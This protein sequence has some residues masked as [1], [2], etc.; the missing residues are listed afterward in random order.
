MKRFISLLLLISLFYVG[1]AQEIGNTKDQSETVSYKYCLI[2]GTEK[3]FSKKVK[4]EVDFGQEQK[5]FQKAYLRDPKTGK[6]RVFNSMVDALNY[7]GG[8]G[9]EFVQAY[10]MISGGQYIY[11]YLMK[12]K[13]K[14]E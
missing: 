11:H 6:P 10:T 12:K 1:K 5:F 8:H 4:I 9:W 3:A 2:E 13:D 14:P 7:F